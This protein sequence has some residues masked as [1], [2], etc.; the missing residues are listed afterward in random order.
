[1]AAVDAAA[2]DEV[3][4]ARVFRMIYYIS[5]CLDWEKWLEIILNPESGRPG[6][7]KSSY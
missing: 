6:N 1:M 3:W 7:R 2:A 4:L 5:L